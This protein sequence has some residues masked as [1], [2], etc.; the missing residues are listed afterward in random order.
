MVV[1]DQKYVRFLEYPC[2]QLWDDDVAEDKACVIALFRRSTFVK[3]VLIIPVRWWND[4][5]VVMAA[6]ENSASALK[7]ASKE[8]RDDVDMV[9][10][11]VQ[12]HAWRDFYSDYASE[13]LKQITELQLLMRR[14]NATMNC[15]LAAADLQ[16]RCIRQCMLFMDRS[17][18]GWIVAALHMGT[19]CYV[20]TVI[21]VVAYLGI[22]SGSLKHSI[23]ACALDCSMCG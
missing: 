2:C 22:R 6:V 23:A 4:R 11:A 17:L 19:T 3:P 1:K 13:R 10:A 21:C 16:L 5:D 8:L 20:A 18:I 9:L 7:H 15:S 12:G 14:G